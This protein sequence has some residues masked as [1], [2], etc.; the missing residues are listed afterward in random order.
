[1]ELLLLHLFF[2]SHL[3]IWLAAALLWKSCG[4]TGRL[5]PISELLPHC[6][7]ALWRNHAVVRSATNKG[8]TMSRFEILRTL[9]LITQNCNLYRWVPEFEAIF[10]NFEI[11]QRLCNNRHVTIDNRH[12]CNVLWKSGQSGALSI[13]S[14]TRVPI[15]L[16]PECLYT[17]QATLV[18]SPD[19]GDTTEITLGSLCALR[20]SGY[21]VKQRCA[22]LTL[23]RVP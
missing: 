21:Y 19:T 10:E 7:Y 11:L 2:W 6:S 12:H 17:P 9:K 23:L 15:V 18:G 3:L 5:V 13:P 4:T 20:L 14:H 8:G 16:C 1:M 22:R